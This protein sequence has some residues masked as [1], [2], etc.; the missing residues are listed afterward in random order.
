MTRC[1]QEVWR[2]RKIFNNFPHWEEFASV[3]IVRR[4]ISR[5]I[6]NSSIVSWPVCCSFYPSYVLESTPFNLFLSRYWFCLWYT[7]S[8]VAWHLY[9][10]SAL[11]PILNLNVFGYKEW[12]E[13]LQVED[14]KYCD[15]NS[16]WVLMLVQFV[17]RFIVSAIR[18]STVIHVIWHFV[19][20]FLMKYLDT[21]K[22]E[23]NMAP[24]PG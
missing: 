18:P 20:L 12:Y 24:W 11:F 1:G 15:I 21:L 6:A 3:G 19:A 14:D 23:R 13:G 9:I 16:A 4:A 17:V 2:V 8:M 22:A 5:E 7:R 10:F